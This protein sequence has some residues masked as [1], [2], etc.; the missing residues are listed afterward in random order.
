MPSLL[1]AMNLPVPETV[2]GMD[3]S[4][5]FYGKK[6]KAPTSSYISYFTGW[7]D[8]KRKPAE[9]YWRGV[10]TEKY[11]YAIGL[12]SFYS[13]R[14]IT[15]MPV[16]VQ[17]ID[18]KSDVKVELL[19]D[20]EIDPYQMHPIARGDSKKYDKVFDELKDELMKFLVLTNDPWKDEI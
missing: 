17:N 15:N 5:V 13:E 6:F 16:S 14:H 9:G 1:G 2:E 4:P 3:F 18:K 7:W 12:R 8:K 10:K 11:T 19:F 20:N